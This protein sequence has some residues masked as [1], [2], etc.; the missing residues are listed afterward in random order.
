MSPDLPPMQHST[1]WVLGIGLRA[2]C[3]AASLFSL[4]T[5]ITADH[6]L[7]I[8]DLAGV[9]T[10]QARIQAPAIHAL[11]ASLDCSI[12]GLERPELT[13]VGPRVLTRSPRLRALIGIDSVAEAAALVLADRLAGRPAGILA[14]P[15]WHT[16]FATAAVAIGATDT[17]IDNVN[18]P[19]D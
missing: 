10:W 8:T 17:A 7:A 13:R 19:L 2:R 12:V 6:G 3:P 5:R 18:Y 9:A 4:V 15:R 11:A 14:G 16:D 1:S